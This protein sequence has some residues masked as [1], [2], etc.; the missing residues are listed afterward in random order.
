MEQTNLPAR[1]SSTSAATSQSSFEIGHVDFRSPEAVRPVTTDQAVALLTDCLMLVRPVGMD[2]EAAHGWLM[3]ASAEVLH[4]PFDLLS[5]GCTKAKRTCERPGQIVPTIIKE[6]QER[7]DRRI[8]Y[9]HSKPAPVITVQQERW[10]PSRE[11]LD[12]LHARAAAK[13]RVGRDD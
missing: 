4:I 7:L 13:L 6:V 2:S 9:H 8:A 3:S 12:A 11:E 10:Q 5:E 1:R